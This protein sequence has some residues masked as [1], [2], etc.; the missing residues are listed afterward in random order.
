[1]NSNVPPNIASNI[2]EVYLQRTVIFPDFPCWKVSTNGI[3]STATAYGII[4]DQLANQSNWDPRHAGI[5]LEATSGMKQEPGHVDSDP[6][7]EYDSM[8]SSVNI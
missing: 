1:M 7:E 2:L 8:S 4:T 5:G 6:S 3:F